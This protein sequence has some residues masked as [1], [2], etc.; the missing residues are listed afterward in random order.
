M[1]KR[2]LV[3]GSPGT[4]SHL[5][6]SLVWMAAA[7]VVLVALLGSSALVLATSNNGDVK[8]NLATDSTGGPEN[9]PHV[10][11]FFLSGTNFDPSQAG[12]WDIETQ[13]PTGNG[14]LVLSGSYLADSQ[15]YWESVDFTLAGGH[16]KLDWQGT[17][18][19][20]DGTQVKHK[21]FWVDCGGTTTTTVTTT[22]TVPTTVTNV[23]TTTATTTQ[24]V[25]T[26][27]TT[28]VG[29]EQV[30]TTTVTDP[31]TTVTVGGPASTVTL[32]GSTVTVTGQATTETVNH[33]KTITKT[34]SGNVLG[35]TGGPPP[36]GG[37]AGA[38]GAPSLPPTSTAGDTQG[39][40]ASTSLVLLLL[41]LGA[42]VLTV[43]AP[44]AKRIR[45]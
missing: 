24:T 27:V 11:T 37:V 41:S 8:I 31:G 42:L 13:P 15:G 17:G 18:S 5:R 3:A 20:T 30:V 2:A 28:T 34:E 25:P 7:V 22:Q 44:V 35:I 45:R 36:T 38:T 43:S 12:Y 23:V 32:P 40:G 16:Y 21:V 1:Y 10:C 19:S 26:T 9:D 29:S 39:G 33:T 4:R 6:R 14:A